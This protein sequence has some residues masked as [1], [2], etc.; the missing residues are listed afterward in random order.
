MMK[1]I[2]AAAALAATCGFA[3]ASSAAIAPPAFR[4]A[5]LNGHAKLNIDQAR[6]IALKA[7]PG[8]IT[9]QELAK[10]PGGS[11]YRYAFNIKDRSGG[12][13]VAV[14]AKTGQVLENASRPG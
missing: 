14:D 7:H 3:V 10:Q 2:V 12:A 4:G 1:S 6:A 13:H 8:V 9:D 11:G 5:E